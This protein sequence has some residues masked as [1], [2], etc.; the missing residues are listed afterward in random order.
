LRDAVA[1]ALKAMLADGSY[2]KIVDKY[3]VQ[4]SAITEVAVNSMNYR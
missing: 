4:P 1:A 3:E 2:K